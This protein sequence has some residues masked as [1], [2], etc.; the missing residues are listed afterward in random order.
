MEYSEASFEQRP[1]GPRDVCQ[2]VTGNT[3]LGSRSSS[4]D[5]EMECRQLT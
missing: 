4:K 5:S 1:R 3:D 2:D